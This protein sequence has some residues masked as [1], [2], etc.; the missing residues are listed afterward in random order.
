M[1]CG[2]SKKEAKY[3]TVFLGIRSRM[4]VFALII[5]MAGWIICMYSQRQTDG[6]TDRYPCLLL[7][8]HWSVVC[9]STHMSLYQIRMM[10]STLA[11]SDVPV[12][13][14]S[15]TLSRMPGPSTGACCSHASAVGDWHWLICM[16]CTL[17]RIFFW[18]PAKVTPIL[19]KSLSERNERKQWARGR[20]ELKAC[21]WQIKRKL[22]HAMCFMI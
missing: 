16:V 18:C 19:N 2:Q 11:R 10:V 13:T 12:L 8:T 1:S 5:I 21:F 3:S 9:I 20:Y 22:I 7:Y 15:C 14:R 6:R 17:L 4:T